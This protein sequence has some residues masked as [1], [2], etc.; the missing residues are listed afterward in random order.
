MFRY[1]LELQSAVGQDLRAGSMHGMTGF[2]MGLS[3]AAQRTLAHTIL[4]LLFELQFCSRRS[5]IAPIF[6][7]MSGILRAQPLLHRSSLQ[8][9]PKTQHLLG[10]RRWA[11]TLQV[12]CARQLS[13][14]SKSLL[15]GSSLVSAA[16]GAML[17]KEV[18]PQVT[19]SPTTWN[20]ALL[21]LMPTAT[22]EL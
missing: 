11:S 8:Q 20:Q 13:A 6:S 18:S 21:A 12:P 4:T 16:T 9:L 22:G 7:G 19:A 10:A 14:R 3:G 5:D 1:D 17:S 15:A 2:P